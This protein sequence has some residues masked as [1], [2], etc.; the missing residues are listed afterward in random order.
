MPLFFRS[1]DAVSPSNTISRKW[2]LWVRVS[3]SER[4]CKSLLSYQ[5]LMLPNGAF[6]SRQRRR[7]TRWSKHEAKLQHT[8]F[9]CILNTFASCMLPRVIGV[10]RRLFLFR[11]GNIFAKSS[12]SVGLNIII[13]VDFLA[14]FRFALEY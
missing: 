10:F 1:S 7:C 4:C 12:G 2:Q 6:S 9:A 11:S 5:L 8:S 3:A 14:Y 13:I